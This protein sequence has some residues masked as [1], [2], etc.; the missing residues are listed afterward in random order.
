MSGLLNNE[1]IGLISLALP[2]NIPFAWALSALAGIF[3]S[4]SFPGL[5]AILVF[6]SHV[7]F[8][9]KHKNHL[10]KVSFAY[11]FGVAV[12]M[13]LTSLFRE[14]FSNSVQAT[15]YTTFAGVYIHFLMIFMLL[16]GFTHIESIFHGSKLFL[17]DSHPLREMVR[18]FVERWGVL[19]AFVQGLLYVFFASS[20]FLVSYQDA[21]PLIHNIY[22][23]PKTLGLI[24]VYTLF[25]I[26]PLLVTL[27]IFQRVE[28]FIP[29]YSKKGVSKKIEIVNAVIQILTAG[30]IGFLYY[31]A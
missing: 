30:I 17:R 25:F 20:W 24:F 6:I 1:S 28:P 7:L 22:G 5:I 26:L 27:A 13:L 29:D 11:V 4:L 2:D 16:A 18:D 3:D 23:G 9:L 19:I 14:Y 21:L 12:V 10:L 31:Y 8:H 15:W